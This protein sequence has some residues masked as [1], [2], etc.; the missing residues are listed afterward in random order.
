[1]RATELIDRLEELK[2]IHGDLEIFLD[3]SVEGLIA[4]GEVDVDTDDTGIII[5]KMED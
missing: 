2:E 5:W 1:L 3:I 4:I